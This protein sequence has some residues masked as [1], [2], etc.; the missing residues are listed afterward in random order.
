MHILSR[1]A[2]AV[3]LV[4]VAAQA[5]AVNWA[6]VIASAGSTASAQV[7][8]DPQGNVI[9]DTDSRKSVD[10]FSGM[11]LVTPDMNWREK[12]DTPPEVVPHFA[13]ADKV[14]RGERLAILIF[15]S[16]P[17]VVDGLVD[18]IVDLKVARPDGTF[19]GETVGS[20]CYSGSLPG[21]PA[22]VLLCESSL[23][24]SAD[25]EDPAGRWTV[26]VLLKDRKR[27]V[28]IPLRTAFDVVDGV[29]R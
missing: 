9:P 23:L 15:F 13:E 17:Q 1:A 5:H 10:G 29:E 4:A 28:S 11:L 3:V 22:N 2:L 7:W 19:A 16:N 25:P 27:G 20:P 14:V 26:E 6:S 21:N 18:T 8:R 24:Y 12:W